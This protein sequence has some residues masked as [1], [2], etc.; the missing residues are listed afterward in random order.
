M[1]E[2]VAAICQGYAL[3]VYKGLLVGAYQADDRSSLGAG[4]LPKTSLVESRES[5]ANSFDRYAAHTSDAKA[6]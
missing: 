4:T 6:W 3:L 1:V 2:Y 5:A